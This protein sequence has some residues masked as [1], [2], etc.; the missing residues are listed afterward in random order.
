MDS[1]HAWA[2]VGADRIWEADGIHTHIE[3]V[4]GGTLGSIDRN[5]Y[6]EP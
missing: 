5:V 6:K 3:G 4:G 2:I 1:S